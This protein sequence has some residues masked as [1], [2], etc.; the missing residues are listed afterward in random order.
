MQE[1][2]QGL[3]EQEFEYERSKN[4]QDEI[5]KERKENETI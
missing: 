2:V 5:N 4:E 3:I 1:W